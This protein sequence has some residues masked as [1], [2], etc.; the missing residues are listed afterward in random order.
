MKSVGLYIE[1]EDKK[2]KVQVSIDESAFAIY[3]EAHSGKT[4]LIESLLLS[5]YKDENFATMFKSKR[6]SLDS[7]EIKNNPY[8]I[9]LD[10]DRCKSALIE[11]LLVRAYNDSRYSVFF[12][13]KRLENNSIVGASNADEV[14]K[15]NNDEVEDFDFGHLTNDTKDSWN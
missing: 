6:L 14:E 5:S 8:A 12:K 15:V 4:A 13:S 2:G 10:S 7:I 11:A 1:N 9:Y 3:Q